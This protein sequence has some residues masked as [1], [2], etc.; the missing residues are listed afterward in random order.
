MKNNAALVASLTGLCFQIL[1]LEPWHQQISKEIQEL[2]DDI[3]LRPLAS[4]KSNEK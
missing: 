1:V 3:R 2:R 4:E